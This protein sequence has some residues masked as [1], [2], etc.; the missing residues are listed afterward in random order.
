MRHL[1]ASEGIKC[2]AMSLDDFY[3]TGSDQSALAESNKGN[4]LVEFRGNGE[5]RGVAKRI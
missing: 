3:L 4:A 5:W 1:F 2:V